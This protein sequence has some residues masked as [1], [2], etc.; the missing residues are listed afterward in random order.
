[1][2]WYYE[3]WDGRGMGKLPDE[4][5]VREH[6]KMPNDAV[7]YLIYRQGADR[8]TYFQYHK[9]WS[10]ERDWMYEDDWEQYA[11]AHVDHLND[12]EKKA[13][14]LQKTE[15]QK[16]EI[17]VEKRFAQALEDM[18]TSLRQ[19]HPVEITAEDEKHA[20]ELGLHYTIKEAV[21]K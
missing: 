12:Q 6:C 8:H 14:L 17:M 20:K 7:A 18:H 21:T 4:K 16:V 19:Q 15:T 2:P 5:A 9:P 1:M 13:E 3:K 11:K 10:G